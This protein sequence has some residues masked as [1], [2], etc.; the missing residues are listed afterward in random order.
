MFSA[1]VFGPSDEAF[2]AVEGDLEGLSATQLQLA[3]GGHV[4][5]GVYTSADVKAAG[6]VILDTVV[7]TKIRAMWVEGDHSHR[8]LRRLAAHM[9]MEEPEH[10]D[11]HGH[12]DG[13]IMI[14]EA[15]VIVADIADETSIFHGLDTVLLSTEPFVCPTAAPVAAP[16]AAPADESKKESSA[17]FASFSAILAAVVA[18]AAIAF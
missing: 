1:A 7:G 6:C 8:N 12:M 14:N 11:D 15:E 5:Q 18:I 13:Y 4:V 10:M 16:T 3:L 2:A 17:P 9:A